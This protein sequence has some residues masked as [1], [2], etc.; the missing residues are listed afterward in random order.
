MKDITTVGVDLSKHFMHAVFMSGNGAIVKRKMYR[1]DSLME[2]IQELPAKA[3]IYAE[4]CAGSH[5][6]GRQLKEHGFNVKLI[7]PQYVKPYVQRNKNDFNDAIAI[8]EA[9]TRKTMKFVP[10]KSEYTQGVQAL[11]DTRSQMVSTHTQYINCIRGILS[12]SGVKIPQRVS[13]FMRYIRERYEE[14]DRIHHYT[15]EAVNSLISLLFNIEEQINKLEKEIKMVSK[16]NAIAQRLITIPGVGEITSTALI[17]VSGDPS[18]FKNGRTFSANLGLT[19]RQNSTANKT[20]L[21][22][23]SKRGNVYVRHLLILCARSLMVKAKKT[24]VSKVTQQSE[25]KSNDKISLWIRK[26]LARN[27]HSNKV[28][29]AVANRLA[30]ISYRILVNSSAIFNANLSNECSYFM[31]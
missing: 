16:E 10:I 26:L 8:G 15:R 9:G 12:E 19:P 20:T 27:I 25:Y 17:T 14:D 21:L 22:G 13:S 30:R 11:H 3:T 28:C 5:Y 29:V 31:Q 7:P 24:V 2:M 18:I 6:F 1:T 4:A 23:I